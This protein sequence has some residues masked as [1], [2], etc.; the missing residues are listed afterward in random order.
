M[1]YS[2]PQY[3]PASPIL[4]VFIVVKETSSSAMWLIHLFLIL[5]NN[6]HF[7]TILYMFMAFVDNKK[8]VEY[9]ERPIYTEKEFL[10]WTMTQRLQ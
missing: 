3:L 5:D 9:H 8:N 1:C 2:V 7:C 10:Q 4:T 6:G